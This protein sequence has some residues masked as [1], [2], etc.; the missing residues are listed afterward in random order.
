MEPLCASFTPL[1]GIWDKTSTA[2]AAPPSTRRF[3][4]G[5]WKPRNLTRWMRLLSRVT[6]L[7]QDRR[8]AM[9]ASCITGLLS[10][11]SKPAVI[12]WCWPE[13]MTPSPRSTNPAI[14]W[15]FSTP[16]WSPAQATRR[17]TFTVAT[18]RR[19][20]C[21]A[22]FRFYARATSSP[23]RRGFRAMKNSSICSGRSRIITNNS[24]RKPVSCAATAIKLCR[25]SPPGT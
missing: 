15:R 2:K 13:T 16:P 7:I 6:F 24:I 9:P 12:W 22:R 20:P 21:F 5:C 14:F 4:T 1:T 23:A 17:S 8:Q 3:S 25:L 18:A 19:A 10:I 11:Y